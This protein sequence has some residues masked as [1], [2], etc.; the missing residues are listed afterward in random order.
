[1]LK[2][3]ALALL[4]AVHAAVWADRPN[5][6]FIAVDDLR[7]ELGCYGVPE[8]HTPNIDALAESGM[9]FDRAFCHYSVCGPSRQ[10]LLTGVRPQHPPRP[11]GED[12]PE[13]FK[14]HGYF[15][16]SMGKVYH[17]TFAPEIDRTSLNNPESWSVPAWYPPPQMY[18]SPEGVAEAERIFSTRIAPKL[19]GLPVAQWTN[20]IVRA[21][22]TD[23]P[24][25]ADEVP[26]DGQIAAR[27]V[28]RLS[29]MKD[30]QP[31]FLAVGFMGTHLPFVAP[32][33][34]WDL[35]P[36]D[37]LQLPAERHHPR[38]TDP[39]TIIPKNET[40]QYTGIGDLLENDRTM[41]RLLRAY[42]ACVSYDDALIGR[43]LEQLD[44]LGLR[45]N[46]LVV[47][48]S[49]HGF[50]L[51]EHHA[52]SK[53]TNYEI[54]TR[55]PLI[56]A[57]PGTIG[58][59]STC[60]ALVESAD[61]Y[62]TLCELAGLPVPDGLHGVSLA[63]LFEDPEQPVKDAIFTLCGRQR[64]G[65]VKADG[66]RFK[67]NGY[68]IRTDRYR[69]VLWIEQDNL[70]RN[71]L[72]PDLD[73]ERI[74]E[75]ELYDLKSDPGEHVNL[76]DRPEYAER[77]ARMRAKLI[78]GWRAAVVT[79]EGDEADLE[80]MHKQDAESPEQ[81]TG[82]EGT[83]DLSSLDPAVDHETA[84]PAP[85]PLPA[86]DPARCAA[87][88]R[89]LLDRVVENPGDR[90]RFEGLPREGGKDV[91]ELESD[92]DTVVLR[93]SSGVAMA[94][95][96]NWYLRHIAH[97]ETD[98]RVETITLP[99]VIPPVPEK[100]RHVSNGELRWFF[101][102]C[103]F[104]YD[105]PWYDWDRTERL[106][107]WLAMNG[108]NMALAPAG[109]EWVW[110][111]VLMEQGYSDEEARTFLGG[112][113]Y[114]PWTFMMKM[115]GFGGPMPEGWIEGRV[116]LQKKTVARMR[117]LNMIPVY[118]AFNG[119]VPS[120]FGER[121]GVET[122]TVQWYGPTPNVSVLDPTSP[123]FR[124]MGERF[125]ELLH[126]QFGPTDYYAVDLFIETIPP[127]EDPA[128]LE[129]LSR[130]VYGGL[131]ADNPDAVWVIQGWMFHGKWRGAFWQAPQRA[132]LFGGVPQNRMLVLD[133]SRGSKAVELD[134]F[135]G[136]PWLW[137]TVHDFGNKTGFHGHAFKNAP[138]LHQLLDSPATRGLRGTA[139]TGEGL[140]TTPAYF[141][142]MMEMMNWRDEVPDRDETYRQYA[143]TR[144]GRK[145]DKAREAWRLLG[146]TLFDRG[147]PFDP[148]V[149]APDR[150]WAEGTFWGQP[151]E[152]RERALAGTALSLLLG[153]RK[154]LAGNPQYEFDL[155][156][157]MRDLMSARNH[158]VVQAMHAAW[159]DGDR[160]GME[161]RF[162]E[163]RRQMEEVERLIG[164]QDEF[165]L[166]R[167]IAAARARA[168]NPDDADLYEYNARNIITL[169]GSEKR[170]I[171]DYAY[172]HWQGLISDYYI[173]R[174]ERFVEYL[175]AQPEGASFD[176]AAAKRH[177][178]EFE[179]AWCR[180][181]NPFPTEPSGDPVAIT[182]DL[183]HRYAEDARE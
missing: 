40:G 104:G 151:L 28:R 69:Y 11:G 73:P 12:L 48:W 45:E 183:F 143:D 32:D 119:H 14:S 41:K 115:D 158:D 153:C 21:A 43:L 76:A 55:I 66:T 79:G 78:A 75:V 102:F 50:K 171:R 23:R 46:T 180:R 105:L 52:F 92:G 134:W 154:E 126:D 16:E 22:A 125:V 65:V 36:E 111:E 74:A 114:L 137:S 30:R 106:L 156:G 155:V 34:Y 163:F 68:A 67:G 51:G 141:A 38:N 108:V 94:S 70:N 29:E 17:G 177:M 2:G 47:L 162:R 95:A 31:F 49:D 8:M 161:A 96:L 37:A 181:R 116:E 160:A 64:P 90:F 176:R 175:R 144:Y 6:L 89:A 103:T 118:P 146:E 107:D 117:E 135:N 42:R 98:W 110:R 84:G 178:V 18:F 140:S 82:G 145:L 138:R 130:N 148:M 120:D 167:W 121:H 71:E 15:C 172:R 61:L 4:L 136:H 179:A 19:G 56:I 5:V 170:N 13:Y 80:A 62:P 122:G 165:L 9:R 129:S 149:H 131:S 27:A 99:E 91:F 174:W 182:A 33:K 39:L 26:R 152:P 57:L 60:E 159:E 35:Y 3:M 59:G 128:Y 88:A 168:D 85:L 127:T 24:E 86:A 173:P 164:T 81:L 7:T 113:A 93:G 166:G 169:W 142:V 101:N 83:L 54:D 139:Y 157:L 150:V 10:C 1:M 112:P 25:V 133:M 109:N 132:A 147:A 53:Y 63:P 44:R 124:A 123:R 20:H 97:E 58:A 77:C 100:I 87:A 72:A